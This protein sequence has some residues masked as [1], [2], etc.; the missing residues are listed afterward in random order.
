MDT[1]SFFQPR[2]SALG[3]KDHFKL[4]F[5]CFLMLE[6]IIFYAVTLRFIVEIVESKVAM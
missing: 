3:V 5:K 1:F 6:Q 2:C 4:D